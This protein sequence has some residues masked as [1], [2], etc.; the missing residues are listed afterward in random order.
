[1]DMANE[2]EKE[3]QEFLVLR[4]E[5]EY[6]A[7]SERYSQLVERSAYRR[8]LKC[9][10]NLTKTKL[11]RL[12]QRGHQNAYLADLQTTLEQARKEFFADTDNKK[13]ELQINQLKRNVSL[14]LSFDHNFLF[15]ELLDRSPFEFNMR[16]S[17]ATTTFKLR[18]E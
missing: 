5:Q 9:D 15:R 6:D 17:S 1:M 11:Q 2:T 3:H 7:D 18:K 4:L 13:N 12:A 14:T 16:L 8:F 10:I